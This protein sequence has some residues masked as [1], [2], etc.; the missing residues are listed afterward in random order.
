VV[1]E[2]LGRYIEDNELIA[3][4]P[5]SPFRPEPDADAD[6]WSTPCE[7]DAQA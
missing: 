5:D 2:K 3:A 7:V 4:T 1:Y 6:V